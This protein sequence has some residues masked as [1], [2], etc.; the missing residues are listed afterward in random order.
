MNNY[1]PT[2]VISTIAKVMEKIA[3]NQLYLYLQNENILCPSQHG[4][5]RG[6]S[7]VARGLACHAEHD[8]NFFKPKFFL[9]IFF[10]HEN[11]EMP[12]HVIC[13]PRKQLKRSKFPTFERSLTCKQAKVYL[14]NRRLEHDFF[15]VIMPVFVML[16]RLEHDF[17]SIFNAY[18]WLECSRCMRSSL[19]ESLKSCSAEIAGHCKSKALLFYKY[20]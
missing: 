1:R 3:H 17:L 2:S 14:P 11:D 9:T 4:F 13:H 7:G 8:L 10:L 16:L 12:S 15:W 19:N 18:H 20:S 6:H 5:R